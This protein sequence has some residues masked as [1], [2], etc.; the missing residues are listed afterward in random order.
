MW[1]AGGALGAAAGAGAARVEAV[2]TWRG[3]AAGLSPDPAAAGAA[4]LP[5]LVGALVSIRR[6]GRLLHP[7]Q[8]PRR[9]VGRGG[10]AEASS[11]PFGR[12]AAGGLAK[13]TGPPFM[14]LLE[15]IQRLGIALG[16]GLLVGLQ[17]TV[18]GGHLQMEH[19]MESLG[20]EFKLIEESHGKN[21]LN[22]VLVVA[23]LRKL[24]ENPRVLKHLTHYHPEIAAEFQKL[25]EARNL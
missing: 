21:V 22:L 10:L 23:Y 16:V 20:K 15:T 2:P 7:P 17:R 14:D 12:V 9:P 19:E 8:E 1:A 11:V 3:E 24:L 25:V 18:S 4:A 13:R 6:R 5:G